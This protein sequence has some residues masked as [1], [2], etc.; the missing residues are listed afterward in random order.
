MKK[1]MNL[2]CILIVLGAFSAQA[3]INELR[4]SSADF[5]GASHPSLKVTIEPEK[6][7]AENALKK[8]LKKTHGV[9]VSGG[10]IL[11]AEEVVFGAVSGKK[12]D[13]YAIVE[14]AD[15]GSQMNFMARFGYD[16]FLTPEGYPE[17]FAAMRTAMNDFLGE[18]LSDY[19]QDQIKNQE[20][21][22][23]KDLKAREKNI[24]QTEKIADKNAGL[25]DKIEDLES[26]IKENEKEIEQLT[27]DREEMTSKVDSQKQNLDKIREK[28][29]NVSSK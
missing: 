5:E 25:K 11:K 15:G 6:K 14:E 19:Y 21:A 1:T 8:Y 7:D 26:D 16:I 29:Q 10:K 3:Q 20:K 22:L 2:F 17:E 13:L 4:T 9:K 27:A 24:A 18:Y 12:M 23:A 28:L